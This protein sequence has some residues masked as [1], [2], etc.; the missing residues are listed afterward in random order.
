MQTP[1]IINIV[2][3]KLGDK[4]KDVLNAFCDGS[5][6]ITFTMIL[7]DGL[8]LGTSSF[9]HI[10]NLKKSDRENKDYLIKQERA[11]FLVTLPLAVTIPLAVTV[12]MDKKFQNAP[13]KDIPKL[14]GIKITTTIILNVILN[15]I[16]QPILKNRISNNMCQKELAKNKEALE[17]EQETKS[18][19]L[20]IYSNSD[21]TTTTK[22]I[23]ISPKE[24]LY[25]NLIKAKEENI[26]K[27][28]ANFSQNIPKSGEL[29]I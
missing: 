2:K 28:I 26:F 29:R 21:N 4:F 19:V 12:M 17:K 25:K 14:E 8:S 18:N 24:D 23:E 27:G 5:Q 7:L 9:A 3:S 13:S 16:V 1:Q 10:Q 15:N 6:N 11:E 20:N 22:P